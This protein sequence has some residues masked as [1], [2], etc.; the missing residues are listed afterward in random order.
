MAGK[1][2]RNLGFRRKISQAMLAGKE[3]KPEPI[4]F[5]RVNI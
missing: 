2:D 3:V 4:F 1:A 5:V